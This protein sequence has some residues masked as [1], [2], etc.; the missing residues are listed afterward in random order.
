[1]PRPVERYRQE[2]LA[3][4]LAQQPE[5]VLDVGCGDGALL[6][7]LAAHG[8]ACGGVDVDERAVASLVAD[9]MSARGADATQLP[10]ANA[11]F[12][13]VV[14]QYTAHH[15]ASLQVAIVEMWRVAR[16]G[17]MLLDP[18]YDT[19]ITSQRVSLAIDRWSKRIDRQRGMVHNEVLAAADMLAPLVAEPQARFQVAHWLDLVPVPIDAVRERVAAQLASVPPSEAMRREAAALVEHAERDGASDDGAIVVLARRSDGD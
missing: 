1:M 16:R 14:M 9:G 3:L 19:S 18:W 13:W 8:I 11:S 5:S 10:Y 17:V 2:F 4:L 7:Q 6:R 12:D 15:L